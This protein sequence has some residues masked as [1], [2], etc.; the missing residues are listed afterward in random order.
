MFNRMDQDDNGFRRLLNQQLRSRVIPPG[1]QRLLKAPRIR[2]LPL[3]PPRELLISRLL[4]PLSLGLFRLDNLKLLRTLRHLEL[5]TWADLTSRAPAGTRACLDLTVLLPD[6]ALPAFPPAPRPWPGDPASTRPG[7]YWRMQRGP[8]DWAWG[9]IFQIIDYRPE[10][11]ILTLQRWVDFPSP[12]DHPRRIHR[13]GHTFTN[14]TS[15]DFTTRSTHRLLVLHPRDSGKGT[16]RA[17]FPDT[18]T[19]S[20][21]PCPSWVDQLWPNMTSATTWSL[22][23]DASW[24][25]IHPPQAPAVFGLQGSHRGRGAVFLSAD[26]PDWCSHILTV[27][28]DIPPTIQA[29]GGT[30][31]VAELLAIQTGVF[32]L[33]SLHLL[34]TVHSDCLGAVKKITRR[35][36]SGRSYLEEGA[37][38][39]ASSQSCLSEQIYLKWLRGHPERSDTPAA[40]WSRQQWNI[41]IADAAAKTWEIGSLPHSPVPILQIHSIPFHDILTRSSAPKPGIGQDRRAPHCWGTSGLY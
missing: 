27:K 6:L 17:E 20:M 5:S 12:P 36:S 9:G 11:D 3:P 29:L 8:G 38:L 41:Y 30:A 40:A 18:P 14:T 13:T 19:L 39:M 34:G 10:R 24:R 35:W 37:A 33:H 31:Q 4:R 16:I 15:S 26:H 21:L 25:A 28:F 1:A 23:T 32:I 22:Y 7:Q 2:L